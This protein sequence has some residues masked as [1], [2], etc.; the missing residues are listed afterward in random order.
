MRF[1]VFF[2]SLFIFLLQDTAVQA[3]HF[4]EDDFVRYSAKDGLSGNNIFDIKQ[5]DHGYLWLATER[6]LSRFDGSNFQQF[7]SDTG[8]NSLPVNLVRQLKWMSNGQMGAF[9]DKGLHLVNTTTL[10]EQNIF[11]PEGNL[12][13]PTEANKIKGMASDA[14]GNIFLLSSSGFYHFDAKGALVFRY[15]HKMETGVEGRM[16]FG[17]FNSLI[18]P[19]PGIVLMATNWGPYI[20]TIA[21]KELL[22]ADKTNYHFYSSLSPNTTQIDPDWGFSFSYT[23]S[24]SFITLRQ[25]QF[26]Y[27][28]RLQQKKYP[29][30]IL[31]KAAEKLFGWSSMIARLDDSTLIV[32]GMQKGFHLMHYY[33]QTGT[34]VIEPELFLDN[35]LCR[36]VFIDKDKRIW[37]GTERGL[38][39]MRKNASVEKMTVQAKWNPM[40]AGRSESYIMGT[41]TNGKIFAGSAG[42]GVYVFD[43]SSGNA[44]QHINFDALNA[45]TT[46]ADLNRIKGI[47]KMNNALYVFLL[48]RW[49]KLD[50]YNYRIT[51]M[52]LPLWDKL[53]NEFGTQ[54]KGSDGT[55]YIT[56]PNEDASFYYSAPRQNSFQLAD[57][58]NDPV[59]GNRRLEA[60]AEAPDGNT[61][62][63][64]ADGLY[65]FNT[66]MHRFDIVIDSFP[67]I[68]FAETKVNC[69][70]FDDKGKM[71][72]GIGTNGLAV[73]DPVKKV[74][75]HFTRSNGLP[76]NEISNLVL[77]K[78]ILWIGTP[79][80]LAAMDI[81][82]KK[83]MPYGIPDGLPDG[84]TSGSF[85]YDKASDHLYIGYNNYLVRFNP[86]SLKVNES[87]P[88]FFIENI[89]APGKD[90]FYFPSGKITL[91]YNYGSLIV[92]L[93][94]INFENAQLQK[95]A[96]RFAE[97]G[98]DEMWHEIMGQQTIVLGNLIP[99]AH[100]L[101]VKIYSVNNSWPAKMQEIA[102]VVDPPFWKRAWFV[103]LC[104]L[105]VFTIVWW[106][107]SA[108][109]NNIKQK[110]NVNMQL[111]EMKMKALHA[112]MNPHFIFNSLN[113]IKELI[114]NGDKQDASRYLSKFAQ[115]IRTGLEQ[116]G[117]TFI[118]VEQCVSHLQQYLEMEKLRF[119]G[120]SY[121]IFVDETAD[122]NE[123]KIAPMLVQPLVENALWHG[124]GSKE[125]DR[126]L[127]IRFVGDSQN[128]TCEIEDN[129]IGIRQSIKNKENTLRTH[130]SLGIVNI[131][132]RLE[133]LNEKYNMK[134][135]LNIIDKTDI[136]G[137][138]GSGTI[139]VLSLTS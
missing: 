72:I 24:L 111:A 60:M 67:K 123:A 51:E 124:L 95:F 77:V 4:K 85:Y 21:K 102:I 53:H 100:R 43:S 40:G 8:K 96:W 81:R 7:Y 74:Y 25:W 52:E 46:V 45:G 69:I 58:R 71:Y 131:K 73:Y 92:H 16:P 14:A 13:F 63:C 11:V 90:S 6:G 44:L 106:I 97:N 36:S 104:I 3:Q 26:F 129:G 30:N 22:P 137:K 57:Y 38:L 28:D 23:D 122:A 112:Q 78:N 82:T 9:T 35:Y 132:E 47:T 119:E 37:I 27:F 66:G 101:Q 83:I 79:G 19:E 18:I 10:Q 126:Q 94:S 125:S 139:A 68:K 134:C 39:R 93:G 127:I 118:T 115:L 29:V 105:L 138:T 91:P 20:Y 89:Q 62:F 76:D 65:R 88:D 116:S 109:A 70:V 120:F 2:I 84:G 12:K 87:S 61:W 113:S 117:Q 33:K 1:L 114:W 108:R 54:A 86:D 130:H 42:S 34:Y 133:V 135:S 64:G 103:T 5:D 56:R 32:T 41:I 80:G 128:L 75:E 99:G 17:K 110:A 49:M 59:L 98:A 107:F 121:S 15:D 136:P 50:P 55:W 48:H 31:A